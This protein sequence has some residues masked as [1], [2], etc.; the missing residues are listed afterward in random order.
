[1]FAG[2]CL[3]T[4]GN[5][6][7]TGEA[8]EAAYSSR[9]GHGGAWPRNIDVNQIPSMNGDCDEAPVISSSPSST[10]GGLKREREPMQQNMMFDLQELRDRPCEIS[11]RA[12][13]S[14]DEDGGTT[15]KKLRLSKEQ[16]ALLEDSFKEHSTL[17]PVQV[18]YCPILLLLP[19]TEVVLL[20]LPRILQC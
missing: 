3:S 15:R 5:I 17:N 20:S 6:R 16:S 4:A 11:S 18:R 19:L 12:A 9:G 13:G 2:F 7:E 1:M 8:V 14:D 10:A